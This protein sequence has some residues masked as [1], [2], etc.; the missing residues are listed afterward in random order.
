MSN[1]FGRGLL[2]LAIACPLLLSINCAQLL[3][4][5]STMSCFT[6]WPAGCSPQEIGKRVTE[7]FLGRPHI[8]CATQTTPDHIAYPE[9]CTWYGALAFANA[10]GDSILQ[11]A[12][13]ERFAPL[14]TPGQSHLI[15]V[16]NHVDMSVFGIVPLEIYT[17]AREV[18][19]LALG[20]A[21][22]DE[23]WRDP[24]AGGLSS[25]TRFW[26]DD[27]FMITALQMQAFRAT[28]NTKYLDRAALEMAAYLDTLQQA[29]GLFY[30]APDAPFYWGRGNGWVAAGMTFL[31]R[32]LPESHP[33]R[34]RILAGYRKMMAALLQYQDVNG[35]WHQLID[36][37]D[38][39]PE[40]S[41]TGMFTFAIISGVK[42]GWL[43]NKKYGL[44]ARKGWLGM[45]SYIDE[46]A[47]LREVC[48]GTGKRNDFSHYL[49][50][51]RN[52]GD[53]HGQAP[54]LWCAAAL[55]Q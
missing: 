33:H 45:V 32:D 42:Y 47:N 23:Q 2:A 30:H 37:S 14:L 41:C 4:R 12:L 39:W 21:M 27:M 34:S 48:E 49:N 17:L 50:R 22:A 35:M 25:Q 1:S 38:L 43:D 54:V 29:N 7:N 31:L 36:R 3:C 5:K 18:E 52:A 19:F 44:A 20:Q 6:G 55:L 46:A 10:N 15:P 13:I 53:Y 11:A 51:K 24:I 8:N 40:S 16:A 26:I 28:R 9:S